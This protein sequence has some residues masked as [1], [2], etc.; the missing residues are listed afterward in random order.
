M[1]H[2]LRTWRGRVQAAGVKR[3]AGCGSMFL[4]TAR[5]AGSSSRNAVSFSSARTTKRFPSPRCASAIQMVR[6]SES[7]T[8]TQPQLTAGFAEIVSDD[9]PLLHPTL[10]IRRVAVFQIVT[11]P[12]ISRGG[13]L[14]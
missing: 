12:E 9:L 3:N 5:T 8:E 11:N 4:L 7:R 14:D 2:G 10:A 6:S 13:Q 1:P